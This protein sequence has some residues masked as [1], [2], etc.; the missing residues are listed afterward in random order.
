MPHRN[1]EPNSDR[2]RQLA[3]IRRSLGEKSLVLIGL[4][5][6][7]KS[8]VGR[9]LATSLN[10]PFT[11]A[12][13]EIEAAA[14]QSIGEIFAEHGEAYFRTGERKVIARL[15]ENGPQ[16]LATG[17]GAYVDPET[18]TAIKEH[19]ISIWL[20]ANLRVLMKRVGRRDNRPLLQVDNPET[21]MKRLM[22]ERNP[23]YAQ[24]DITVE[25]KEAP[26]E[27]MV[28]SIIDAL[29]ARLAQESAGDPAKAQ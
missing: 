27:V 21:V 16:V 3:E 18:R 20:K 5:G 17:G 19:G 28:S 4:M 6:A 26:H 13:S 14:G 24:A 23:V 25:S 22:A 1:A 15:L 7:G 29:S 2:D 9:R 11:D 8:A 10:L 12:D